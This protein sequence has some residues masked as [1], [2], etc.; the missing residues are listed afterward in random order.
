LSMY[1]LCTLHCLQGESEA[2]SGMRDSAF[3]ISALPD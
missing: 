1:V 3:N 2:L